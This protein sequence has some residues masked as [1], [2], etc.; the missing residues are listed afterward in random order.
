MIFPGHA[1]SNER[2]DV[3]RK[4]VPSATAILGAI[5]ATCTNAAAETPN[6]RSQWHDVG[7]Q[8]SDDLRKVTVPKG[9]GRPK[10]AI[11][12]TNA[13]LF[14]G[15]GA[16]ARP[17][18]ILIVD[19]VI[20]KISPDAASLGAPAG[21]LVID[22]AGRTV[23]PGLIDLHTHLTY[24][25]GGDATTSSPRDTMS[26]AALRG[27]ER[28]RYFVESGVTSVRDAASAGDTPF[29]LK[30]WVT[31]GK[32]PGPRVFPVGQLITGIGG[33]GS[34]G[35][36]PTAPANPD[37]SIYEANGADG[38]RQAV[39]IQ[40]KRGADWIK[41]ASHY[42]PEEIKAAVDEAHTLGL[43]V[44]VDSETIYI[45]MAVEAGA[46]CIEHPLPRTDET[47]KLMAKKGTCSDM[48]LV[49]YQYINAAEGY[50]FST[51]RRFSETN[52]NNFA[53]AKR[54]DAAG[55]KIGI[56]TDLVVNWFHYLP[57]AY[58][59][60]LRNYETLGHSAASALVEATRVNSEI[61]GMSDRLGTIEAGKLADVI[62]VDGHPDERVEDLA[63][64]YRVIVNGRVVVEDGH[65]VYARHVQ[66]QPPF[67]TAPTAAH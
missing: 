33:H 35:G 56:G 18:A 26:S 6:D 46:D 62:I 36:E 47:I 64:L 38:F 50:N 30:Q 2:D 13:R 48:T 1:G 15:T 22:A 32:I 40:F 44:M 12:I 58:I 37:G 28:L 65:V 63:K 19:G 55:V 25:D 45:R 54:L 60:E 23:M 57:D 16:A 4:L 3:M 20:T 14:D 7:A 27:Q 8:V 66:E 59:Q 34:E 67:T 24:Q 39:R 49:P 61:L 21:A 42:T 41:L 9:F 10:G 53:T 31:A 11:E 29:E 43:R 5:A 51:S 17:A 52:A